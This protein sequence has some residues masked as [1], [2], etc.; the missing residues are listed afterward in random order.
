MSVHV[1][2]RDT[3]VRRTGD[4]QF[5][6]EIEGHRWWVV[7]G[8]NGGFVAAI[9]L[10]AMAEE[11]GDAQR[12]PRSL[13]VHYPGAPQP[14][15]LEIA[16]TRERVGRTAAYLSARATQEG[17]TLAL[18]L[19]A[20]SGAFPGEDFQT[21]RIPDVALPE[22]IEPT[23]LPGAPPFAQNFE[24][25]FASGGL[26][27][28]EEEEAS[29]GGWLRLRESRPLDGPLAAAYADAWPPA[30]FW[31]LS[32]FAVV[33]TIDLTI[34]FRELPE[35]DDFVYARFGSLREKDGLW[36]EN[37][38]LWSRDGRLL[39]QSRQLAAHMPLP[40]PPP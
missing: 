12:P 1:F 24:Y 5:E 32:T 2:D 8:P 30:V 31:R 16:V 22:E 13:S 11:L 9:L 29:T 23:P 21:A 18:A 34:H 15:A 33:P 3:A 19:A 37:G 27:F 25:R 17:R 6:A 38:E 39:V 10:R 28:R 4:G 26:P 35:S 40:G 36:E 7:R 14:G 20:F